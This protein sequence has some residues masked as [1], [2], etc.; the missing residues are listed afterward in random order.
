MDNPFIVRDI[1]RRLPNVPDDTIQDYIDDAW[2]KAVSIA[3]CITEEEFPDEKEDR[4]VAILRS[5]ILRWHESN[6]AGAVS[7]TAGPFGIQY[8]T[9]VK[10]GYSLIPAEIVDLQRLCHKQGRPFSFDTIPEDY[11][12]PDPLEEV[13]INRD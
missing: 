2:A 9:P 11:P 13:V 10:R 6:V 8:G 1:S 3:P 12:P 7:K 4:V 5:I